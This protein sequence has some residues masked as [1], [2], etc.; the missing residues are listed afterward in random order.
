MKKYLI[1][2]SALLLLNVI[3]FSQTKFTAQLYGGYSLPVA[4]LKGKFPD[5]LTYINFRTAKTLLTSYGINFGIKG[6][7]AVDSSG[8]QYITAGAEYN[9]F[10]GSVDYPSQSYKNKV[11]IFTFNAGIEYD[12]NP[13]NKIVPYIGLE[14]GVN[15]F[16]GKAEGSGDSI[17]VLNR[18]SESRFGVIAGAGVDIKMWNSGG[19][20]FGVKYS[21]SNLIGKKSETTTTTTGSV[22]TDDEPVTSTTGSDIP[23]NDETVSNNTGKSIN[24]VQI[25]LGISYYF[26]KSLGKRK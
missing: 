22:L 13:K 20:V 17:V 10:S 9:T 25:Y 19:I 7:I 12:I 18:K 2:L 11:N 8:S 15:F 14:L 5:S 23:L 4:D 6:K 21:L 26:G 1:F 3:L 24:Y 16:S